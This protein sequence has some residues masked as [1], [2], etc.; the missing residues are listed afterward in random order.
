MTAF[1]KSSFELFDKFANAFDVKP[2][3]Y[4]DDVIDDFMEIFATIDE[5]ERV[6]AVVVAAEIQKQD[7]VSIDKLAEA[8]NRK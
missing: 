1:T 5:Y 8:A 4:S 7:K 6:K 2:A 3:P